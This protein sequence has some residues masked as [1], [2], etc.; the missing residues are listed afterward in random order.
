M[1]VFGA[2][3]LHLA[4]LALAFAA[5][6]FF[7]A[8]SAGGVGLGVARALFS[9]A[10]VFI[11]VSIAVLALA[12]LTHDF[13]V[14]YI[15]SYTDR[16]TAIAYLLSA[17]WA[18]Q[19]G[20]LLTWACMLGWMAFALSGRLRVR[21]PE[22]EPSAMGLLSLFLGFFLVVLIGWSNPF[23]LVPGEAPPDGNG[24]NPLLR[25][26]LMIFHPPALL[27]GFA[28]YG[29]P[30]AIVGAAFLTNRVDR[31]FL[32]EL[33]HWALIA[34]VLLTIGN[35]LGMLWA[36]EELGWGGYWGWDPV[37]NASLIPW[38]TGTALLHLIIVERRAGL[39]RGYGAL[40]TLVTFWLT[41]FGTY[42]T[43][44]G[45][46][47]SVHAFGHT[48]VADA[49]AILLTI[50]T[51]AILVGLILRRSVLA[52]PTWQ[53]TVFW[54]R[55]AVML[56]LLVIG[57]ELG[58]ALGTFVGP[59]LLA[60]VVGWRAVRPALRGSFGD[61]VTSLLLAVMVAGVIEPLLWPIGVLASILVVTFGALTGAVDRRALL[62]VVS[63]TALMT[64]TVGM[65]VALGVGVAFGT[66]LPLFSRFFTGEAVQVD[67]RWYTEWAVPAGLLLLFT[68]GICL[69][70]GW[71]TPDWSVFRRRLLPA[72]G[73]GL[74]LLAGAIVAGVT[75]PLALAAFALAGFV[76][77]AAVV[78]AS[79][80][81]GSWRGE[82]GGA[83]GSVRVLRGLGAVLGHLG[84]AVLLFGVAGEA[85]KLEETVLLSADGEPTRFGRY[86]LRL[87]AVERHLEIDREVLEATVLVED[88]GGGRTVLG[89]ARHR[90]RS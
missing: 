62:A 3:G 77:A 86:R 68:T 72:L 43:R 20:S 49:I 66:L 89:P 51:V 16:T 25:N 41:L 47:A 73:F 26:L 21:A 13:R 35:V 87:E 69:S 74:L 24:L 57:Q 11:T 65:L 84:F 31:T 53:G 63:R 46:I 2:L 70:F 64:S 10:A 1:P 6:L 29:P 78:R 52:P 45:I 7:R 38:L 67:G 14:D 55:G 59:T 40:L 34:W 42:L 19:A 58:G 22:L 32:R 56:S 28:A 88:E 4:L 76:A 9:A 18:G 17:V 75:N 54:G 27:A 79:R 60:I 50:A 71:K 83:R 5:P 61:W 8:R 36:Y 80:L 12:A 39:L 44:S 15:V 82:G 23:A 30:A 90:Y 33:R 85:N 81:V 48:V 37:E